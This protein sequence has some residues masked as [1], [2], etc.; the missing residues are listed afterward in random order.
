[1]IKIYCFSGSGH[2]MAVAKALARIL[3]CDIAE[4]PSGN[5]ASSN[6]DSAV[7]IFPVYCQ[8][9]PSPVTRFLQSFRAENIVLIATYG[10]ISYGNAL[11]EAQKLVDGRVIAGA[12][13]PMGHTFL[14][15]DSAFDETCLLP[16]A[17]RIRA[18]QGVQIPKSRKNPLA[19]ISPALRSRMGVKLVKTARCNGCG[20]CEALCPMGAIRDGRVHPECIRCLRCVTNCPQKALEY[21]NSR[22]LQRYLDSFYNKEEYVLFL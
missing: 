12:Y 16:I 18:P 8:N 3:H 10:K 2:S 14:D 21:K 7:V 11:Y 13:I 6:A 1:M 22:V 17:D 20:R 5:E 19:N 9:I 15:G 4:I